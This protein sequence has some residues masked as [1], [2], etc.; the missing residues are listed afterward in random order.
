MGDGEVITQRVLFLGIVTVLFTLGFAEAYVFNGTTYDINGTRL[1]DTLV[2]ITIRDTQTFSIIGS[3]STRTNASGYFN[4]TVSENS[5]W[6]YQVGVTHSNG[7]TVDFVGQSLP[8]LP[9]AEITDL[10]GI[11]FYL[12]P[13]GTINLTVINSSGVRL[14][15]EYQISDNKL[16]FSIAD[17]F[18]TYVT[19]V[20]INVPLG[21]NYSITVFPNQTLPISMNWN[22]F[23]SP[24]SYTLN[25]FSSST[26][27]TTTKVLEKV[28]NTTTG[29][30]RVTGFVNRSALTSSAFD[31]LA[32]IPYILMPGDKL[33]VD[34]AAMFYNMSALRSES[35]PQSDSFNLTTGFYNISLPAPVE[36]A[37]YVFFAA[38]RNG[39]DYYG[40]YTNLTATLGDASTTRNVSV[41]GL[42]GD[43]ANITLTTATDWT[44]INV[45][46]K[47]LTFLLINTSNASLTS[48]SAMIE[49]RVDYRSFGA[50]RVTF[51]SDV[52]Q[53]GQ[54]RYSLP[55][56]NTTGIE[57]ID[58]YT[59]QYAPKKVEFTQAQ[60][61]ANLTNITFKAFTPG[62]IEGRVTASG[63]YMGLYTS[64]S[65]CDVPSPSAPCVIVDTASM[66]TADPMAA[67]MG[68]GKVSFRMGTGNISVHY[69]NVDMLASGPPDALFDD[70]TTNGS[71]ATS[72]FASIVRFGS[73]GPTIYDYIL[74]GF[75]Y[76][77]AVG[78]LDE[79]G[80]I[81]F[82][83]PALYN[84]NWGV[85]WNASLNGTDAAAL[86]G[87]Y[88]YYS[89][90]QSAWQVL[91]NTNNTC[92][93]DPAGIT[94]SAPCFINKSV[95][96][97]WLRLPHFSGTGP[98]VTGA[99]V[100]A[101]STST[102]TTTASSATGEA[103]KK[104][105]NATEEEE[106]VAE[107]APESVVVEEVVT[108][109]DYS[110]WEETGSATL[111]AGV[112]DVISFTF[113]PV[114]LPAEEHTITI[115]EIGE[116]TVTVEISSQTMIVTLLLGTGK[117]VDLNLD[118]TNDI[119][120]LLEDIEDGTATITIL[121][122]AGSWGEEVTEG[123]GEEKVALNTTTILVLAGVLIVVLLVVW[124][125][126]RWKK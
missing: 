64:N 119:E 31:T 73:G 85:I 16:G 24:A 74:V 11:K 50:I 1:N 102:T 59:S 124:F 45:T 126:S 68:G 17:Q 105:E 78:G 15:F 69:V 23:S 76:S 13:A 22:N 54:A 66:S 116:A 60:L 8:A 10:S 35:S 98:R 70:S 97:I 42:L 14:P 43:R 100:A 77:D 62:D 84:D 49:T 12:R 9:V 91:M 5:G 71:T 36:S 95:N 96:M 40:G 120:L 39:S 83:L 80:T 57:R 3:N 38:G 110:S 106:V 113:T 108:L 82:T 89:A 111:D 56:L 90:S 18:G 41:Y 26:Y 92:G 79:N 87:N 63:L 2:N 58:A 101:A 61:L 81:N 21:R 72:G 123:A 112:G 104:D 51:G 32:V 4:F 52:D 93:T 30:I 48:L 44:R 99:T 46:T 20:V 34:R 86:A 121:K 103:A 53:S 118:G 47:R 94:V 33:Y 117:E 75:P 107:A 115:K 19:V 55:L 6:L 65:S 29:I 88:T 125:V 114:G 25:S 122:V 27:N 7:S 28:F 37:T 109:E 67:I